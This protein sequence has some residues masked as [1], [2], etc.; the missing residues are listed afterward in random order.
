[1]TYFMD[2]DPRNTPVKSN[3]VVFNRPKDDEIRSL[4]TNYTNTNCPVLDVCNP[5][6]IFDLSGCS[7]R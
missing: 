7:K 5:K 2:Q 6:L 3:Y 4:E 1:M